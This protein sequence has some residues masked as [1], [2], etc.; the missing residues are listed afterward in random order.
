MPVRF[1]LFVIFLHSWSKW[2]NSSFT[3]YLI[4]IPSLLFQKFWALNTCASKHKLLWLTQRIGQEMASFTVIGILC[5]IPLKT[6]EKV[7]VRGKHIE[8]L[9]F[10]PF[11]RGNSL[12]LPIP[13]INATL[14]YCP[15]RFSEIKPWYWGHLL[16]PLAFQ[17]Q[18]RAHSLF[19]RIH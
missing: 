19:E 15:T 4:F 12:P 18:T 3:I 10:P 9:Y 1:L 16:T 17:K 5:L 13:G 8:V 14:H 7:I 2:D 11:F 6:A